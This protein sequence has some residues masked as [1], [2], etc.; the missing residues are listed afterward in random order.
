M[1]ASQESPEFRAP[2]EAVLLLIDPARTATLPQGGATDM[3]PTA[4][5]IVG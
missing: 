1:T 5:E 3:I 4:P 2:T